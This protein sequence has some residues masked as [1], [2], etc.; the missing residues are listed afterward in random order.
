MWGRY[1]I[2]NSQMWFFIDPSR[3]CVKTETLTC[4]FL[5]KFSINFCAAKENISK[6]KKKTYR[7]GENICK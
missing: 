2:T 1:I 4:H 3:F 7:M 5:E 6:I